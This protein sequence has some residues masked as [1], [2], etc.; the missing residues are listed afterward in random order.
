MAK[1]RKANRVLTVIDEA[2]E[3]YLKRG[4]DQIDENGKV[5]KPATGGKTISIVKYNKVLATNKELEQT[6]E[7]LEEE[8]KGL[9]E[10][11]KKLSEQAKNKED[12]N[13][14]DRKKNEKK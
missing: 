2:V 14:D 10:E 5:I 7:K 9:K 6:I 13:K 3:N 8:N 1:V 11:L 4:Y 12:E